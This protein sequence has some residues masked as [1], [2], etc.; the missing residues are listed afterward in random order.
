MPSQFVLTAQLQ[1]RG[2]TNLA[3]VV[4]SIQ[5][6]LNKINA[7]INIRVN[8][9]AAGNIGNLNKNVK[10][11]D[12]SLKAMRVTALRA[13]AALTKLGNAASINNAA[14]SAAASSLASIT[15]S[16][17]KTQKSAQA[18]TNS[19]E[20]FGAK[21]ALALKRF[22]AFSIATSG[23]LGFVFAAKNA[24][25][26]ALEFERELVKVSQVTGKTLKN[27]TGLTD[28][29]SRLST[30]FGVSSKSLVN[31]AQVLAQAGLN[32]RDTKVALESLAKT[33][34]SPTFDN[35]TQTTEGAI[36][37]MRQFGVE[38]GGLEAT[39]GS[40]N[41]VA[42]QFAVE[43]SDIIAAVRRAGGAFK[44]A[45]GS[46]NEFIALFTSVR[47]T[48]RESAESIATGFRTIF[49]RIQRPATVAFLKEIGVELTDLN[50][51]FV[52]PF[53][54][55]NRLSEALTKLDPRDVRFAQVIEELGGFRQV[56]KVI[57][58]IQQFGVAQKAL[59]VA[60]RGTTTLADDAASA[61]QALLVQLSKVREEFLKLFRTVANNS[62]IRSF[63]EL[64]VNLATALNQIADSLAPILPAL[65]SI[66]GIKA[67]TGLASFGKGFFGKK[68][69]GGTVR[70]FA[71]GGMV[72][73]SG[74]GD[75]Q[76]AMLEPGEFVIRKAAVKAIGAEK[77]FAANKKRSG[78]KQ[79]KGTFQAGLNPK[80]DVRTYG[81]IFMEVG[82]NK[83]TGNYVPFKNEQNTSIPAR[84]VGSSGKA[85]PVNLISSTL[86][87]ETYDEIIH[88]TTPLIKNVIAQTAS[89]IGSPLNAQV[90][91]VG[92]I[93]N[94]AAIEGSIF[95]GAVAAL[96]APIGD[97]T[98]DQRTFDYPSG[99]QAASGLFDS[100]LTTRKTDAKRTY[101]SRNLSSIKRKIENDL[102]EEF[103]PTVKATPKSESTINDALL[104]KAFEEKG[105][106]LFGRD[107]STGKL[108]E[109]L[110]ARDAR[111]LKARLIELGK[112]QAKAAG[113]SVGDTVPAMLTPGEFVINKKSASRIGLANLNKM[114]HAEKFAKGGPV[115][116]AAGGGISKTQGAL[117]L[118]FVLPQITSSLGE[119]G[120]SIEK[121]VGVILAAVSA[122]A[123][124]G[125]NKKSILQDASAAF[126]G[127]A[128]SKSGRTKALPPGFRAGAVGRLATGLGTPVGIGA[129]VAGGF[130]SSNANDKIAQG[131]DATAQAGLGG[132]ISGAGTGAAIGANFGPIGVAL[133][134]V[135]GA[136]FGLVNSLSEAKKR[137]EA[138]KF[139]KTFDK[140][141]ASLDRVVNNKA[142]VGAEIS[143][144][145]SGID[146]SQLR[147]LNASPEEGKALDSQLKQLAPSIDVLIN[148]LLE[149]AKTVDDVNTLFSGTNK[150]LLQ[151]QANLLS[152]PLDKFRE[153][154]TKQ[155]AT[156][157][158]GEKL[159]QA[160]NEAAQALNIQAKFAR[161]FNN[162]IND[163]VASTNNLSEL[164]DSFAQGGL[165]QTNFK[166]FGDIFTRAA[167]GQVGNADLLSKASSAVFDGFGGQQQ[168]TN[169]VEINDAIR[170]LPDA[171]TRIAAAPRND[172]EGFLLAQLEKEFGDKERGGLGLSTL[173]KEQLIGKAGRIAE[174]EKG[175]ISFVNRINED[176]DSVVGELTGGFKEL[177]DA[178]DNAG[179]QFSDAFNNLIKGL[180]SKNQALLK[181][182]DFE[183]KGVQVRIDQ[184]K[185]LASAFGKDVDFNAIDKALDKQQAIFA[186]PEFANIANNP[187]ALAAA[188]QETQKSIVD[189]NA[190][191]Q[192]GKFG[193]G[194]PKAAAQNFDKLSAKA[195]N[196]GTALERLAEIGDKVGIRQ[197]ELAREQSR[198][199]AKANFAFDVI[200]GTLEEQNEIAKNVSRVQIAQGQGNLQGFSGTARKGIASL[201]D[202]FADVPLSFFGG[203]NGLDV[204]KELAIG[205]I[206]RQ[207]VPITKAEEDAIL[208]QTPREQQLIT[209]IQS[210]LKISQDA[211]TELKQ[212]NIN[213]ANAI[214]K[215]AEQNFDKLTQA[216]REGFQKAQVDSIKADIKRLE[217][218]KAKI[219]EA[220]NLSGSF[221]VKDDE[222]K[223]IKSREASIIKQREQLDKLD[224]I[225]AAGSQ[226]KKSDRGFLAG[227]DNSLL[228][229]IK[230]LE[231]P[232]LTSFLQESVN[233][234][235][236]I[237]P[238]NDDVD[239]SKL[240]RILQSEAVTKRAEEFG[241]NPND[242]LKLDTQSGGIEL[243]KQLNDLFFE[244][245][246]DL[247]AN[248]IR[249]RKDLDS[250]LTS[251]GKQKISEFLAAKDNKGLTDFVAKVGKLPQNLDDATAAI[252]RM[253]QRIE[254]LKASLPP[255]IAPRPNGPVA[256]PNALGGPIFKKRGTDT[257]PA[258]LTPGE[259]VVNAN[260]TK[261]NKSLLE[262]INDGTKYA[263]DGG[264]ISYFARGGSATSRNS[265]RNQASL[266]AQRKRRIKEQEKLKK[267][268]EKRLAKRNGGVLPKPALSS[269]T[270]GVAS[271]L[272][273]LSGRAAQGQRG[274]IQRGETGK[275]E[276]Q[277]DF[278]RLRTL[279]ESANAE[280]NRFRRDTGRKEVSLP[281]AYRIGVER[282]DKKELAKRTQLDGKSGN[283]NAPGNRETVFYLNRNK[284]KSTSTLR[285]PDT[286]RPE[287]RQ[288]EDANP[289]KVVNPTHDSQG[290]RISTGPI[291]PKEPEQ[292][293]LAI[294]FATQKRAQGL[295]RRKLAAEIAKDKAAGTYNP[296]DREANKARF[297]RLLEQETINEY[298]RRENVAKNVQAGNY[299]S[300]A[301][302]EARRRDKEFAPSKV[303]ID[304]GA[305]SRNS[306]G[307]SGGG[308]AQGG[309]RVSN[310]TPRVPIAVPEREKQP[311]EPVVPKAP[312]STQPTKPI[313]RPSAYEPT[314]VPRPRP[315]FNPSQPSAFDRQPAVKGPDK[316]APPTRRTPEGITTENP[317]GRAVEGL[318]YL[319]S[320]RLNSPVNVP[321]YA[322]DTD[323][324]RE[325]ERRREAAAARNLSIHPGNE[326][327]AQDLRGRDYVDPK[328]AKAYEKAA[329]AQELERYKRLKARGYADGG[330]VDSVPAMLTPGE[331]VINKNA[332]NRIGHKALQ[333]LNKGG[334]VGSQ[335]TNKS[336]GGNSGS[337]G[338]VCLDDKSI[339]VMNQFNTVLKSN[340]NDLE[341]I[342]KLFPETIS[343]EHNIQQNVT[344]NG[345]EVLKNLEGSITKI[346]QQTVQEYVVKVIKDQFPGSGPMSETPFTNRRATS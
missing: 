23:I 314:R 222:A 341:R 281:P 294:D 169:I 151:F 135:G 59:G 211:N 148:K 310:P 280:N 8:P 323:T 247:D 40:L 228:E 201:L 134:A 153:Q 307:G 272:P 230:G 105:D 342:A 217:V 44:S 5:K 16:L 251:G 184:E 284:N 226:F 4:S 79:K 149:G 24:F 223:L 107:T 25:K 321:E 104:I 166:G 264:L 195:N 56:S 58:L 324:I 11:L 295:A 309:N 43:S 55:V 78:G 327:K 28:E 174:G 336:G 289:F 22:A 139:E 77:L 225:E 337:M 121:L 54:A 305:P 99:L 266:D 248:V 345:G 69:Q 1:M 95:E 203:K 234:D 154:L 101:N 191:I 65:T 192:S 57:P 227:F 170:N 287:L 300:F 29:I 41:A 6:G 131:K 39:L 237:N 141:T 118:L 111:K 47:Q 245:F 145:L 232:E 306:G 331:F 147:I 249:G 82:K 239:T 189:A 66:A 302:A 42:G 193:T 114:N 67:G 19:I 241:I 220:S 275:D 210:L 63:I 123:F 62:A 61:Q 71:R 257:V 34:L 87:R 150:P 117:G 64:S 279:K 244:A 190:D 255:E 218:D 179:K 152:L 346:F 229:G 130:V 330:V 262:S 72:P 10:D 102:K 83:L 84:K 290:R 126:T 296:A 90:N 80:D 127:Q 299:K 216:I 9:A 2:P 308:S 129:A 315:G 37:I 231:L 3:S 177:F 109:S 38:A 156:K 259:F 278:E 162:A 76:P 155:V 242:L 270:N 50:N 252:E 269:G 30:T 316:F 52:G 328:L 338:Y 163:A 108:R 271:R 219:E 120:D 116:M 186:G 320:P 106:K 73:G 115:G 173:I 32:A 268:T 185:I 283:R 297:N 128:T 326:R 250:G 7:N 209:E 103:N 213:T 137:L 20:D 205:E 96:G 157:G 142:V 159:N 329:E 160:A 13:A 168:S 89:I 208:K 207:G 97:I 197:E 74:N 298:D 124:S 221:G 92:S 14:L 45:G 273:V 93:P 146:D 133:G 122:A 12:A 132:F 215:N 322:T 85:I 188:L 332:A 49:T 86:S 183:I 172:D 15:K 35:I 311:I 27:L 339:K 277:Y 167:S 288:V 110:G 198:R 70:G 178:A 46:F 333:H 196:L 180:N 301:D 171:L 26:E 165:P 175:E 344:V 125:V 181:A 265:N 81:A 285:R 31:V 98:D 91:A 235:S 48:T 100:R 304:S 138:V 143:N 214:G 113:G 291:T 36:A 212:I 206:K 258:M 164:F 224:K 119:F 204:K 261:K 318:D 282:D 233:R 319:D 317:F 238:F 17:T 276:A 51:K 274:G 161:D 303:N 200:F 340:I 260:A 286:N 68:A 202:T 334:P 187:K 292:E 158:V 194:R 312:T 136:A 53:E 144:I 246:K 343:V 267:D 33:E 325:E 88:Q 256:E 18:A 140:F 60:Q 176:L 293:Q 112:I 313:G 94:R 240:K 243:S 236:D 253:R 182:R 335:I 263:A 254:D 199:A 75:T 21:S